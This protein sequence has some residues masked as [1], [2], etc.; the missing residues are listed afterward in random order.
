MSYLIFITCIFVLAFARREVGSPFNQ[1]LPPCEKGYT[2]IRKKTDAKAILCPM[3]KDEEGFLSEWVAYYQLH[4][5]DH[6]MMFDDGSTD[7]S[8]VELAPWIAQGFVTVYS[9]WTEDSLQ[10]NPVFTRNAFKRTMTM[11][12][13]LER[14]CKKQALEWGFQYMVSLDIDEYVIPQKHLVHHRDAM[15]PVEL[16]TLVDVID[17]NFKSSGKSI[18]CYQKYNFQSSPHILEPVNL[19]TIEAYQS[20]MK[21][22]RRMNY[23]TTV[24]PKCGFALNGTLSVADNNTAEYVAT[25]CNFHGCQAH[26]VVRD[27]KFCEKNHKTQ[28]AILHYHKGKPREG[29]IAINHYSRSLEK[30]SLKG[31]WGTSTGEVKPGEDHEKVAKT[32][33]LNKFFQRSV[34]WKYDDSALRYSCQLRALIRNVTG[35]DTY[36]RPGSMWYRNPEFGRHVSIPD[37]RGRYGR[38]NPEG[39]RYDDNNPYHYDGAWPKVNG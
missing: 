25:C 30:H 5:F 3:F 16:L 24:M 39:F 23:Y 2:P 21:A 4:G 33:D 28:I 15:K 18:F 31:N 11:K 13:L 8:L 35:N 12:A 14:K 32:Y 9:N 38:P 20:R 6:I 17:I 7:N 34:G 36:Y 27:S 19:L 29:D 37:K 1:K 22:V 10:I 26:D